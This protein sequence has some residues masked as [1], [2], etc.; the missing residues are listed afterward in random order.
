[1][2]AYDVAIVG[3]GP[4]GLTAAIYAARA[5]LKTLVIES[6][7]VPGQAVLTSDIEN[8]PGFPEGLNGFD[9]IDR[10]KK[11]AEKSGAE[12]RTGDVTEIA[13]EKIGT[14]P[15]WGLSLFSPR[16]DKVPALSVIIASGARPKKLEVPGED[17]FRGKGLSYC[18]VCDGP[19]FRGK[20]VV[21]VGG[22][23]TAIEEAIFLTKFAERVTV[24]HRRERL[25]ATKILEERASANKKIEFLW[26][27]TVIGIAGRSKVEALRIKNVKDGKEKDFPVDGVFIFV[28][29]TPN[30]DFLKGAIKL[31]KNGYIEAD[32]ELST[33]AKGVFAAGD[34]RKKLLRQVVTA[35]GDGA[36]AAFSARLYVEKLKSQ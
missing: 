19:F 31:D 15:K 3:G 16:N 26:N 20:N 18:A 6:L 32:A 14:V 12:F 5:R 33:S 34:A 36:I 17:K 8:Y 28:G 13:S 25:R 22:G 30:T 27:S 21:V 29:Y 10:F 24:I 9:L 7:S 2:D 4:A 11:Q 1:M 23:D 35:T